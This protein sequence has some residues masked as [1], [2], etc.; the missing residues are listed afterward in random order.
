MTNA[1]HDALLKAL[2]AGE[3]PDAHGR[4][5]PFGGRFVPE[6]LMPAIDRLNEGLTRIFD[7]ESYQAALRRQLSE[8]VGRPTAL[9]RCDTLSER[10]DAEVW[11]KREDLAH[12][13]AQTAASDEM[14]TGRKI[15]HVE[16]RCL[17]VGDAQ[18]DVG[19][20]HGLG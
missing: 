9:T 3:L 1:D 17:A 13:G 6:T 4:F 10:W 19:L 5:G 11:L 18:H 14:C 8:W 16:H 7:S 15:V 20:R 2:L 12:T